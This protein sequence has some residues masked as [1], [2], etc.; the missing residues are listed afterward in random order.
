MSR[1]GSRW[2]ASTRRAA[3]TLLAFAVSLGAAPS[4]T[5]DP[6]PQ[7]PLVL[8]TGNRGGVYYAY[9]QG[10]ADQVA[11]RLP[12]MRPTVVPTAASL[13]NLRMVAAGRADVAFTLA[14]S[15]A[16][17]AG[18]QPPFT[19]PQP[20]RA[21]ARLYD[22]YVQLVVPAGSPVRRLS[23]LRGRTVSTGAA[24]SGTELIAER[25]L[26]LTG[27]DKN[28]DI[29]RRRLGIGESAAALRAGTLDAFF[30]SGGLPTET[31]TALARANAIRLVDLGGYA[32]QMRPRYGE[33]YFERTI[34]ASTYG[35]PV[36][37]TVGVPNFLVVHADMDADLAYRLT[38]LLFTE[39]EAIA[40]AHPEAR[41]L[42]RL[43][44]YGTH[45]VALHPGAVRYYREARS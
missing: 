37:T 8:A 42:N 36:T 17:A 12:R 39:R 25:L 21:L 2:A 22:N 45:P 7:G 20:I 32:E 10:F 13:D 6:G 29:A 43:S 16:L 15:A 31:I 19:A 11:K 30:F 33:F 35:L 4:C 34:P 38:R 44:A 14:D 9:G 23:D 27:I 18:G 41:R 26:T 3:A 28:R 24:G 1:A 40:L 5:D